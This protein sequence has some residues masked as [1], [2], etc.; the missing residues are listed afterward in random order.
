MET[1]FCCLARLKF[2]I[3]CNRFA[4][5]SY[6]Q[7]TLSSVSLCI[8]SFS[9][10]P[11][12]LRRLLTYN[13]HKSTLASKIRSHKICI[14]SPNHYKVF[15][16]YVNASLNLTIQMSLPLD[17]QMEQDLLLFLQPVLYRFSKCRV[18]FEIVMLRS[19]FYFIEI[20]IS[21]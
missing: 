1:L 2:I 13:N 15:N 20:Q 5:P 12:I 3:I 17:Q 4:I 21:N 16:K 18:I 6:T 19:S 7:I 14:L 9:T 10:C 8:F 11:C